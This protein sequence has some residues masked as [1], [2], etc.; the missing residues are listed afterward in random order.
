[1]LAEV[2]TLTPVVPTRE[3]CFARYCKKLAPKK[4]AIVDV[5]FDNAG[6]GADACSLVRCWKNPSGCIVEE[7]TNGHSKVTW[8]EHSRCREPAAVPSAYRAVTAGGLAFGARRWV[9]A[10]RLQCERMVFSVA[11]NV[12]ARD[13]N[14]NR[15]YSFRSRSLVILIWLRAARAVHAGVSTLA[16]RR[17]VLK[18]AHRMTSSLCRVIVW[19]RGLA[20]SRAARAGSGEIRLT[21]R[22]NAGDPGEPL[23]LIACAVLSAWLPVSPTVL[24]D[25]LKDETRRPEVS[26]IAS[27]TFLSQTLETIGASN[28]PSNCCCS[29]TSRYMDVLFNVG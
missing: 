27:C 7:Q 1:M 23:G 3:F 4:W 25:F 5:S 26:Y 22:R 21:S 13:S 16:G 24:V 14:G 19:S 29:G 28:H 11:T 2:Q 20:W 12:P 15:S 8:V 9:A 17:S 10:L 6:V 18:L